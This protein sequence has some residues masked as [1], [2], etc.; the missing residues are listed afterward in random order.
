MR[1]IGTLSSYLYVVIQE[2]YYNNINADDNG[3]WYSTEYSS[4]IHSLVSATNLH[5]DLFEVSF[6]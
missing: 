3:C 5:L 6:L 4:N 1:A 2:L